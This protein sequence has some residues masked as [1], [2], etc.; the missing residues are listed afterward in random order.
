MI[1]KV[2]LEIDIEKLRYSLVG[3]GYN[4]DDAE[5]MSKEELINMLKDIIYRYIEFNYNDYK[6]NGIKRKDYQLKKI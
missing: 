3:T 5:R 2:T 6:S 4:I 1:E